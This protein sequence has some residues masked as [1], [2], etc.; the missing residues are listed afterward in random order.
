MPKT[1]NLIQCSAN[2]S[3]TAFYHGGSTRSWTGKVIYNI[4]GVSDPKEHAKIYKPIG[5][6]YN[7]SHALALE[8][9]IDRAITLLAE[10][11]EARFINGAKCEL[12]KWLLYCESVLLVALFATHHGEPLLNLASRHGR[13]R[14]YYIQPALWLLDPRRRL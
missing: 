7:M 11:L 1:A 14:R 12:E 5:K 4:F 8:G 13:G 10:Q 3:Q 2:L 6:L 9:H